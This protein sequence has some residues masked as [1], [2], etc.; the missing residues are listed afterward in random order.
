MATQPD[1]ATAVLRALADPTRRAIV[2]HLRAGA[3]PV[4]ELASRFPVSR[5]AISKHLRILR[6]AELVAE[7]QRGR[8][9][10]YRLTIQPVQP[11]LEWLEALGRAEAPRPG[12]RRPPQTRRDDW[13]CW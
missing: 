2:E 12:T 3:L 6:E 9:R 1:P 13:K 4:N 8:L 7:E 5:P 11:V 10:L